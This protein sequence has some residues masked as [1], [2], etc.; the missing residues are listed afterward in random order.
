MVEEHNNGGNG[1]PQW[2]TRG[3]G[4]ELDETV[5]AAGGPIR[6]PGEGQ[7]GTR[8]KSARP[9]AKPRRKSVAARRGTDETD[10]KTGTGAKRKNAG[11]LKNPRERKARQMGPTGRARAGIG[12]KPKGKARTAAGRRTSTNKGSP[13]AKRRKGNRG[14]T[15]R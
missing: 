2:T 3:V 12:K 5:A 4:E 7:G 1:D 14:A 8:K 11:Q 10:R 6:G 13:A 15:R 9:R